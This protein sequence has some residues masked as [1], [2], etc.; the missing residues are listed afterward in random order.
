V[1]GRITEVPAVCKVGDKPTQVV[2]TLHV[3]ADF[4]RGPAAGGASPRVIYFIA[5][6]RA[7]KVLREQDFT[8]T[9]SFGANVGQASVQGEE[10]EVLLPVSKTVSAAAYR[11]FVGFRLSP[12]E[13]AYNRTH[14][15]P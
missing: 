13:L 12:D 4:T 10:I 2:A 7:D 1:R 5:L 9:P 6:T 11:I 15:R 14:T 8:F 3:N